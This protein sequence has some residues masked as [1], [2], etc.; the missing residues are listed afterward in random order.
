MK[1]WENFKEELAKLG[2]PLAG[3]LGEHYGPVAEKEQ[4]ET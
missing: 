1:Q 4:E 3:D 2:R